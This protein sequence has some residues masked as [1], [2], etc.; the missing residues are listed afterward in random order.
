MKTRILIIDDEA[1]YSSM[2]KAHLESLGYYEVAE[3]NDETRSLATAHEFGPDLILLDV[4]MPNLEG[5]E[6]AAMIR[7][8]SQLHETP[9]LFLTALVSESDAPCGSYRSG[10]NVFLPKSLPIDR[11]MECIGQTIAEGRGAEVVV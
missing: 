5:S 1:E 8:D 11:L 3:E 6:V 7:H 10:G 2:L 4:M 9:I